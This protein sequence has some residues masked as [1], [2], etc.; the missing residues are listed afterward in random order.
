MKKIL[1]ENAIYDPAPLKFHYCL[2]EQNA[3]IFAS[4]STA[5]LMGA[6]ASRQFLPPLLRHYTVILQVNLL[7]VCNTKNASVYKNTKTLKLNN[8][9]IY[10]Q[11]NMKKF[12]STGL[13]HSF[14]G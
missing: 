11:K 2:K 6:L 4:N 1:S 13:E 8:N 7:Y 14:G 9:I 12:S 5:L 3:P 10:I